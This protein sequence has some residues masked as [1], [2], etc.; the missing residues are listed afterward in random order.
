M[1][2]DE[3]QK[4]T[5]TQA[6]KPSPSLTP[7]ASEIAADRPLRKV[8]DAG[9]NQL[10]F[11]TSDLFAAQTQAVR[12]RDGH[13]PPPGQA[14]REAVKNLEQAPDTVATRLDASAIADPT[15]GKLYLPAERSAL[16]ALARQRITDGGELSRF[17]ADMQAFANRA[18][19]GSPPLSDQDVA[20]TF[21]QVGRLL[22]AQDNPKITL[23]ASDRLAIAEQVM[24]Q[25]ASPYVIYQGQ[26]N[27]CNVAD[28]EVAMYSRMPSE[29]AKL[30]TDVATTGKYTTAEGK[31]SVLIDPGQIKPLDR[32]AKDHLPLAGERSHA[33]QIFQLTAVNAYFAANEYTYTDARGKDR[34][35]PPG[36]I[37]YGQIPEKDKL[38]VVIRNGQIIDWDTSAYTNE[39]LWDTTTHPPT[40]IMNDWKHKVPLDGPP[41]ADEEIFKTEK[42]LMGDNAP[43]VIANRDQGDEPLIEQFS[44]ASEL[45][46]IL[47]EAKQKGNM[48]LVFG[49]D[50]NQAP[51]IYDM[52][53]ITAV[54]D[55]GQIKHTGHEL[56]ITDY[57]PNTGK[58]LIQNTATWR[59]EEIHNKLDSALTVDE[60][61]LLSQKFGSVDAMANFRNKVM[62]NRQDHTIDSAMELDL[63]RQRRDYTKAGLPLPPATPPLS[64][65]GYRLDI[66][67]SLQ[68]ASERWKEEKKDGTF[69]Q[70]EHD[71]TV[72]V[73]RSLITDMPPAKAIR[74]LAA[75]SQSGAIP[76]G[77]L[78]ED[79]AAAAGAFRREGRHS[80]AV[81][82]RFNA[83][84][85][86]IARSLSAV[87]S[88]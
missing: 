29:A 28:I 35:V 3:R 84:M 58:V 30:V 20:G 61:Y 63:V 13:P 79:T 62:R 80:A 78:S 41:M 2:F 27:T 65:V 37:K 21:R 45:K 38:P 86:V 43:T 67:Q 47:S 33:S 76:Q 40:M 42:I 64:D 9:A 85:D 50:E 1:E 5:R 4:E 56:V 49:I 46:T 16:D 72:F 8:G 23:N 66:A 82:R 52:G 44:N 22:Q 10:N 60:T 25:A 75:A 32:E 19:T 59:A 34:T 68:I 48:P 57:D 26:H 36:S 70:S 24:H 6:A 14:K 69:N 54:D 71:R 81:I 83:N 12:T 11:R 73:A 88:K 55:K 74:E 77:Q 39:R 17:R 7:S 15:T 31:A 18:T 51:I 87:Q 53:R